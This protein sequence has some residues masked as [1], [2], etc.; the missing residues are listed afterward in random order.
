MD[1][2]HF[3]WGGHESEDMAMVNQLDGAVEGASSE[4]E[5]YVNRRAAGC[6][7]D[8]PTVSQ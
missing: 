7:H 6:T 4:S 2:A 3:S 8:I 5:T 1:D